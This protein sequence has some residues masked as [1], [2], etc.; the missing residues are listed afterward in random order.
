MTKAIPTTA[1]DM[2]GMCRRHYL[3]DNDRPAGIFAPEI[4]APGNTGRRADLIWQGVTAGAGYELVGHEIKVT[5]ADLLAEL[6][7][8]TKSHPWQRYCDRWWLVVPDPG[9]V[10]GLTLP[11]T[12]GVYTP[13][14]GRRTR[15]MTPLVN[16]PRLNP[17]EQAPALRT[18]ATWLHWRHHRSAS[19]LKQSEAETQRLRNQ[20]S[21]L[22]SKV[23]YESPAVQREHEVINQIIRGLGRVDANGRIGDWTHSVD[24][25]DVIAA[26]RDL[27][28]ANARLAD[29]QRATR[30]GEQQLERMRGG[31][32]SLLTRHR[33]TA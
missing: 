18:L 24:V 12:W 32:D 30:H 26:L 17:D 5:R 20:M 7:D 28:A 10:Q 33:K 8:L 13:P 6:A 23:P 22:R 25:D 9:I 1:R 3:P 27:A 21:E 14:S 2:I 31:I 11:D 15:S 29:V 19:V 16:A 4:G